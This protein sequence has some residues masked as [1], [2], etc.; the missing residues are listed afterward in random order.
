MKNADNKRRVL[1]ELRRFGHQS[2]SYHILGEDMSF[3]FSPSGISGVIAY[4]VHAKVAMGAGDPVCEISDVPTFVDEFH[5]YC[6]SQGWRCCFQAVTGR[7][8]DALLDLN[9]GAIK[10]GEEPIFDLRNI[11]WAGGQFRGLRRD[12]RRAQK[13]G[14]SV[15]EYC[16]LVE[17]KS[18]WETQMEELSA[19][20]EKF[21]GSGEFAFLLGGPSLP[22]PGERKYFLAV[23]DDQVEAFMVCT[24]IYARN[25]IYF[26]LMRRKER[27]LSG[28]SQLLISE[29]FRLLGEQGYEMAT[30]G[31]AP[32]SNQHVEDPTHSFIIKRA[33][34]LAYGQM[35]PFHRYKPIYEFKKQFGP[36]W[37]ENRYLAYGPPG[38][39]PI[40]LYTLLKAYD[41]SGIT[42]KLSRQIQH[43]WASTRKKLHVPAS[44]SRE[45]VST[46]L[47]ELGQNIEKRLQVTR[48]RGANGASQVEG[49]VRKAVATAVRKIKGRKE[50]LYEITGK[51]VVFTVQLLE[52][53][54]TIGRESVVAV[55][56]GAI[57]GAMDEEVR[58]ID[59][60]L[61]AA[62]GNLGPEFDNDQLLAERLRRV[63]EGVHDAA[64]NLDPD[65]R[66]YI[67]SSVLEE[68]VVLEAML[69]RMGEM[70]KPAKHSHGQ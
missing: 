49:V 23:H 65:T 21:K 1:G 10:I 34:D 12:I 62:P 50:G 29:S 54:G 27:P 11:S 20:W 53:T 61:D 43:V 44:A 64:E 37:W 24:P 22:D 8:H 38:F 55:V 33:L 63:L 41:P 40:I 4:V 56:R 25:G 9:F 15:V 52:K 42:G 60:E 3:F 16:P 68:G 32:L 31:T 7:C 36:T 47:Q 58:V 26:D 13:R 59:S 48:T 17:R 67:Q 19:T 66:E 70:R 18:V 69:E 35:G 6:R 39:N 14:L 57:G 2:Q 46:A 45:D 30:L 28:T 5:S 51:A